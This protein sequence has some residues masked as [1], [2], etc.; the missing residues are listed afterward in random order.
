MSLTLI[1]SRSH[2]ASQPPFSFWGREHFRWILACSA[3]DSSST[4]TPNK[5]SS[6]QMNSST[7]VFLMLGAVYSSHPLAKE[8]R[9][10]WLER[11]ISATLHLGLRTSVETFTVSTDERARQVVGNKYLIHSIPKCRPPLQLLRNI[12][13]IGPG[14]GKPRD[15][16]IFVYVRSFEYQP[17][18][19][20]E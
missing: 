7:V 9:A 4:Q 16:A 12:D 8:S 6:P 3:V 19:F 17:T 5:V 18:R 11:G 2:S 15:T 14:S 10:V 13:T 1:T 20:R